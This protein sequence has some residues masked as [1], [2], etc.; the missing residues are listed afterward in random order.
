MRSSSAA[1]PNHSSF[2]VLNQD[3]SQSVPGAQLPT[4]GAVHSGWRW[5]KKRALAQKRCIKVRERRGEMSPSS[6]SLPTKL[7]PPRSASIHRHNSAPCPSHT[8]YTRAR[9]VPRRAY[10]YFHGVGD[11]VGWSRRLIFKDYVCTLTS[12]RMALNEPELLPHKPVRAH[13]DRAVSTI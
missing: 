10:L 1:P 8:P 6:Q 12:Y 7:S 11:T 9:E 5:H 3:I 13:A 4:V 2:N